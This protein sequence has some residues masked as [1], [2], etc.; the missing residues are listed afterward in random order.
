MTIL[1]ALSIFAAALLL[2]DLMFTTAI[3]GDYVR[4][5]CKY[6]NKVYEGSFLKCF[7]LQSI[8][9]CDDNLI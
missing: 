6:C 4:G 3:G 9:Q 7:I 8:H 5:T 1:E 2:L